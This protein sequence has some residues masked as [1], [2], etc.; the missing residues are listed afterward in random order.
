MFGNVHFFEFVLYNYITMQCSAN[1][2]IYCVLIY[3]A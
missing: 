3:S 1:N 2:N